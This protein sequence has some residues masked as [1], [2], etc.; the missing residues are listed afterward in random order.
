LIGFD[1]DEIE[2]ALNPP[3]RDESEPDSSSQEIN[4]DSFEME[5]KCPKC[6]FEFDP[7]GGS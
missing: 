4:T 5:C 6:G 1:A 3:Q 7:K 2:R